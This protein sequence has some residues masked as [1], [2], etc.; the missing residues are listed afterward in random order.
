MRNEQRSLYNNDL[1]SCS[2]VHVKSN[3]MGEMTVVRK[4]QA[5]V[6]S[7][8][9]HDVITLRLSLCFGLLA[10]QRLSARPSTLTQA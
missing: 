1:R 10:R 2:H 4:D 3:L 5:C 8:Q 7:L 6:E 9:L